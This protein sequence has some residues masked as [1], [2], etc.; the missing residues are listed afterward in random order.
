MRWEPQ[1]KLA[2]NFEEI[3]RHTSRHPNLPGNLLDFFEQPPNHKTNRDAAR[4]GQ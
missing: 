2:A 4:H 1:A 3:A